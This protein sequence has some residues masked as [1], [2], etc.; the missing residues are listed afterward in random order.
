MSVHLEYRHGGDPFTDMQRLGIPK[1]P[2]LDFSVNVSPLGPPQ[3]VKNAWMRLIESISRYPSIDGE[4]LT[5]YYIKRFG[6]SKECVLPGNGSIEMIYLAPRVLGVNRAAI[7]TPTF[8]DYERALTLVGA[9]VTRTP[10][11]SKN[12]FSPL[13]CN[14][15]YR[16]LSQTDALFI[17][18]PNNPTGTRFSAEELVKSADAFPNKHMFVDEAFI[19]FLDDFES[20]T[21]M[22]ASRIRRNILVFHSLT[23]IYALPGLRIGCVIGHPDTISTLKRHTHPWSVN[24]VVESIVQLLLECDEYETELKELCRAERNRFIAGLAKLD[25]LHLFEGSANFLTARWTKT[26]QLDDLLRRLLAQG[27]YVR[28]CRNF[29]GLEDNYFR[30]CIRLPHDNDRLIAAIEEAVGA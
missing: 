21:L 4:P 18:N 30:F 26:S 24:A 10:L 8:H 23:K 1:K 9:T 2:V 16:A 11:T 3:N 7:V 13:D 28:D 17:C 22:S 29:P 6:I 27:L 12:S 5:D 20:T 25:G 15:L 19:Q 14:S